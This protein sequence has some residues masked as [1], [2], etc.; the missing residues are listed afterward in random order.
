MILFFYCLVVCL[1][2][3]HQGIVF[4]DALARLY[5]DGR[6]LAIL[7]GLDVVSHLHGLQHQQGVASLYLVAN[8]HVDRG[9][10]ARQRSLYGVIGV[11]VC[12]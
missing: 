2:Y 6:Y 12:R 4:H 3:N 1:F 7:L 8:I 10:D 5:A 11:D 9:D